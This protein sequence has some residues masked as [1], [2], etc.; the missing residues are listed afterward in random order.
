M[1]ERNCGCERE[2]VGV[3]M[4]VYVC[5]YVRTCV[6]SCV[7][8]MCR[9]V[10]MSERAITALPFHLSSTIT[11]NGI[12]YDSSTYHARECEHPPKHFS[13]NHFQLR[14]DWDER[15]EPYIYA[16]FVYHDDVNF[17]I[18]FCL[19]HQFASLPQLS[20]QCRIVQQS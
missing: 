4:Y 11:I 10:R 17:A 6:H 13:E 9:N 18:I 3:R 2:W 8:C 16:D 15:L 19:A 7:A 12:N 14:I 20:N 1:Q 5:L